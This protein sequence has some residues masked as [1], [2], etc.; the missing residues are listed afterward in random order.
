MTSAAAEVFDVVMRMVRHVIPTLRGEVWPV[1][2]GRVAGIV[3]TGL[4]FGGALPV[5]TIAAS[6]PAASTALT[7][8]AVAAR[9]AAVIANVAAVAFIVAIASAAVA[10]TATLFSTRTLA[11][12]VV[13]IFTAVAFF[14]FAL[15]AAAFVFFDRTFC[16]QV[17]FFSSR[18]FF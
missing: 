5:V 9:I 15:L 11:A 1:V 14:A 3:A 2:P 12:A 6:A 18:P 13:A 4:A 7:A 17:L 16:N 8:A 10:F